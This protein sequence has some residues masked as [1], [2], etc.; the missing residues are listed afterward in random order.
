M[1][2]DIAAYV[3]FALLAIAVLPLHKVRYA[4]MTLLHRGTELAVLAM[5]VAAAMFFNSPERAPA[6]LSNSLQST[7]DWLDAGVGVEQSGLVWLVGAV[8]LVAVSLP[9]LVLFDFSRRI[10]RPSLTVRDARQKPRKAATSLPRTA[11]TS[12]NSVVTDRE[13]GVDSKPTVTRDTAPGG[14]KK[15]RGRTVLECLK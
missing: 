9:A 2:F 3:V 15:R 14:G 4:A 8:G 6:V 12:G 5:L 1:W 11:A 10:A 7:A 13:L